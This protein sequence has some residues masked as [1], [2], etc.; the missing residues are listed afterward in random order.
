VKERKTPHPLTERCE[1]LAHEFHSQDRRIISKIPFIEHP[2]SVARMLTGLH[3]GPVLV[4]AGWLHD[5]PEDHPD[6]CPIDEL[7]DLI[8]CPGAERVVAIVSTV[9]YDRSCQSKHERYER[10][11]TALADNPEAMPVALA[12][13]SDNL[14]RTESD[15]RL[16]IP[17]FGADFLKLDPRKEIENWLAVAALCLNKR[18][19]DPG[20]RKLCERVIMLTQSVKTILIAKNFMMPF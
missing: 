2:K 5:C 13:K 15:L 16:G 19:H 8:G 6:L 3:Y 12:D 14:S 10:Y 11:L 18:H 7:A 9:T 4:G 17:V 1:K 20:V